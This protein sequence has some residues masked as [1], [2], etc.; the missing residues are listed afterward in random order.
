M[1]QAQRTCFRSCARDFESRRTTQPRTVNASARA[2]TSRTRS[3]SARTTHEAA[4]I[5]RRSSLKTSCFCAKWLWENR[6]YYE[7]ITRVSMPRHPTASTRSK[8]SADSSPTPCR[9][10]RC[11]TVASFRSAIS[12]RLLSSPARICTA[13]RRMDHSMLSTRKLNAAFD[14]LF[15][16][17]RTKEFY[18]LVFYVFS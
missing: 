17:S 12:Y 18:F 5:D 15:N 1:E 8:H 9:T 3:H 16:S 14:I 13:D 11:P 4:D 10:S 2:S 7:R 6:D